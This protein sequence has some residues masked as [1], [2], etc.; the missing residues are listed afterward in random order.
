MAPINQIFLQGGIRIRDWFSE[1]LQTQHRQQMV[2][3]NT[4]IVNPVS[5]DRASI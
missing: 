2:E 4:P 5:L 3:R 1:T